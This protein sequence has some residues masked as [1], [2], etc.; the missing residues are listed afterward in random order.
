MKHT[1]KRSRSSPGK[2][3]R[4]AIAG[5]EF[6]FDAP[7]EMDNDRYGPALDLLA[8]KI[9]SH[10]WDCN[11]GL[12]EPRGGDDVRHKLSLAWLGLLLVSEC[13]EARLPRDRAP[14][15]LVRRLAAAKRRKL[16]KDIRSVAKSLKAGSPEIFMA[17]FAASK[18][19]VPSP[20]SYREP[21]H[22]L[23]LL[24]RQLTSSKLGDALLAI[25][26]ELDGQDHRRKPRGRREQPET[27]LAAALVTWLRVAT[28]ASWS[29][30]RG[31]SV[32]AGG[33]PLH[34][35]AAAFLQAAGWPDMTGPTIKSRLESKTRA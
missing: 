14:P 21:T 12:W 6:A 29:Y 10:L 31:D 24:N 2:A 15:A 11:G 7:S 22:R 8:R 19:V 25:A 20:A 17:T 18:H 23:A 5:V 4:D 30:Q 1:L 33:Q 34:E 3:W 32:P 16:V 13:E 9:E 35:V 26:H 27:T 28:G